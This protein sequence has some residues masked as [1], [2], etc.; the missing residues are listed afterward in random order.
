M[1][2]TLLV[3]DPNISLSH[4]VLEIYSVHVLFALCS[5]FVKDFQVHNW[6]LTTGLPGVRTSEC[7]FFLVTRTSTLSIYMES[8]SESFWTPLFDLS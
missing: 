2:T 7:A 6:S 4:R 3:F 1:A 8:T 5:D